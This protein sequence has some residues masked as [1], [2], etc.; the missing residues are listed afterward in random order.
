MIKYLNERATFAGNRKPATAAAL[1]GQ[2]KHLSGHGQ[3]QAQE[4]E[5]GQGQHGRGA[6][7]V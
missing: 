1:M 6:I 3:G 4:Q 7:E 2:C 5:Q